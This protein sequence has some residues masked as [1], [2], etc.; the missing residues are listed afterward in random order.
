MT[1]TVASRV[2]A[3]CEL[4]SGREA[5]D[6]SRLSEDLDLDSLDRIELAMRLEDEFNIEI[7][8]KDVDRKS[9]GTVAGL[10]AYVEA[11]VA[12]R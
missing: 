4:H 12:A 2:K 5:N 3:V 9:L 10:I 7:P 1:A 6:D 8:D 11:K